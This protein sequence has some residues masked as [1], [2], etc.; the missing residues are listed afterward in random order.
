MAGPVSGQGWTYSYPGRRRARGSGP[1]FKLYQLNFKLISVPR[2]GPRGPAE[3]TAD[4]LESAEAE[5]LMR[6]SGSLSVSESR[7]AVTS[8]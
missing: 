7:A 1:A 2:Q 4:C 5:R 8:Q 6:L 3:A